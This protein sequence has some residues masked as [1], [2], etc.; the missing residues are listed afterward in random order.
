MKEIKEKHEI[1][2][3]FKNKNSINKGL[4]QQSHP[5]INNE[6]IIFLLNSL[7]LLS[8]SYNLT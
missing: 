5:I 2:K 7:V 3:P 4:I 8:S 6:V 1:S